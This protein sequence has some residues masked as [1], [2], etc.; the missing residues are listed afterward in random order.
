MIVIDDDNAGASQHAIPP[1][2]L[3]SEYCFGAL[4]RCILLLEVLRHPTNRPSSRAA[5]TISL[6][7]AH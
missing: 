4:Q 6:S 1:A 2:D 7:V 5:A 3:A